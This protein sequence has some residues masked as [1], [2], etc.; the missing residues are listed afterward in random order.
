MKIKIA[1]FWLSEDGQ[2]SPDSL[3]VN[4]KRVIQIAALLRADASVTFN[5]KNT[6]TTIGFSITREHASVREA[7]AFL[8]Q[9]EAE[10]PSS[11]IVEFVCYDGDGGESSFYLET[12]FLEVTDATYI[13]C[14]TFHSYS[15]VGGRITI[16]K[17]T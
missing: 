3:R 5:R 4:G 6:V 11:G 9:H 16:T 7:E 10:I 2:L 15:L 12:G 14:S 8:I 17:P 1:T 13:G